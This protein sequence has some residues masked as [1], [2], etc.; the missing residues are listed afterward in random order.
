M[1]AR[2]AIRRLEL[3]GLAPRDHP[4]P[5]EL[6]H[7]LVDAARK[8]L[9]EALEQS[10]RLWTGEA[11]VRIRRLEV[12]LTLEAA[13]EPQNF[14][15]VLARAIAEE[16]RRAEERGSS[17]GGND[18]VVYYASRAIYLA[19]LLEALAEGRATN[20]W[21]LRDAEG[22][23]LLSRSQ[24]IRTAVLAEPRVGLE[25]LASLAPL[26]RMSVLGALAPIEADRVLDQLARANSGSADLEQC[27]EAVAA[28]AAEL[29][30][31]ASALAIFVGA[32]ARKP[33]VAGEP[34]AAAA[35]L[36]TEI[37][38]V[39]R[40]DAVDDVATSRPLWRDGAAKAATAGEARRILVAAARKARPDQSQ[41]TFRFTQFG[42]LLLL[43]PDLGMPEIASLVATWPD[44]PNDTAA[45]IGHAA[46]GLCAGRRRFAEYLDDGLWRELFG[47][48]AK[49]SS[50]AMS[51]RLGA[52]P[53]EQ[54]AAFE[55]LLEP[56]S[57]RGD[58]R[59]LLAPRSLVA[60]RA[61]ARALAGLA[62]AASTRFALRLPG[63]RDASA[64]FLWTN[65][66]AT[67]AALERRPG[68]WSAR[69]NRPPLDVLLSL[70]RVAEGS[71]HAPSGARVDFGR[72]PS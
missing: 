3:R 47:L 16:L 43:L 55:P 72:A 52:I 37:D 18:G 57:R 24:A 46:L 68:G 1:P 45:L 59:F 70:A 35:R 58:A 21:W 14:A 2:V 64:P 17:H 44:A 26:R 36:W 32:F 60:S 66:L 12:D 62:R 27:A 19:A 13:F 33:A 6:Q 34:L 29:P 67:T 38:S 41:P 53:A 5:G 4:A 28:A 42:G 69:L 40:N 49:A 10:V 39:P 7:R 25:A 31:G 20:Q 56:L 8:F 51:A 61:A 48:D 9:P 54:W 15:A 65:L 63:F 22:L 71:V 30:E 11:V 50:S 23:R